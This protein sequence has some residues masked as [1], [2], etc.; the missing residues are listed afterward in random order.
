M[1]KW[2]Q[3]LY[4]YVLEHHP[5][6]TTNLSLSARMHIECFKNRQPSFEF[7]WVVPIIVTP[8]TKNMKLYIVGF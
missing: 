2:Y 8:S 6:S 1:F 5:D 4:E 3:S 7:V